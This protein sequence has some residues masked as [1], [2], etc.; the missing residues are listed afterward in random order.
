MR[1][2]KMR[3]RFEDLDSY[4][5]ALEGVVERLDLRSAAL[6]AELRA[7]KGTYV[8]RFSQALSRI[9]RWAKK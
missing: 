5:F 3:K 1:E 4:V 9:F 8:W 2:S 7:W 6:Q